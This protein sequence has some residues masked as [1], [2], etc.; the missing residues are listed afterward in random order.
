M[1]SPRREFLR[2]SGTQGEDELMYLSS[3][4]EIWLTF[5]KDETVDSSGF[6]GMVQKVDKNYERKSV[7]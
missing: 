7:F 5:R 3:G 6:E 4:N 2:W 1:P